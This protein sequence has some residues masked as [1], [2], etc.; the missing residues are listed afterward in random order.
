MPMI[1]VHYADGALTSEKKAALGQGLT[2]VLM[3]IEGGGKA[4]GPTARSIAWVL[5]H[6]TA[7][8]NLL[9]GGR[10]DDTYVSPPGKFLVQ[11]TVP[12]GALSQ[13]QKTMMHRSV[14]E[15]FHEVFELGPRLPLGERYPSI[16]VLIYEWGEGNVGAVGETV[17]LAD[18]GRY[19]GE[20]DP[21]MRARSA[22]YLH[23]RARW[24][25]AA[26][27]PE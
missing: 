22:A 23:A 18:I 25:Q 3:S 21:A 10:A 11:I 1:Q 24:R 27:F 26:G 20:G 2:D 6:P 14:D 19:V 9:I 8:E 7:S 16:L 17:G 15:V 13:A 4:E 5:F 12:E